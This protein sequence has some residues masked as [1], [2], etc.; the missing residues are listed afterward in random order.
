MPPASQGVAADRIA[1]KFLAGSMSGSMGSLVGNP[2]DVLK[3]MMMANAKERSS[4]GTL[5]RRMLADQGIGGFYRGIEANI[6]RAC[7]L[8]GT[9][10]SCYDQIKSEVKQRT[11]WKRNDPRCQFVSATGAGFF[12]TCT[13]APF[14]N[15]RT[16]LMNQPTDK[17][18]YDGFADAAGKILT[19]EGPMAFYRGFFPMWAR[20][21]PQATLQLIIF[22]NLL[23]LTGF[24]AL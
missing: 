19:T 3:T 18:L 16:R 24:K 2:F 22:D 8:N 23:T 7:V 21:A 4:V 14:D 9:K 15:L 12:M 6:L 1:L 11:G 10:M 17:K 5:I 13:V 20:F